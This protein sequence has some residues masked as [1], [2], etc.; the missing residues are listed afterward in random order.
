MSGNNIIQINAA[1]VAS[2]KKMNPKLNALKTDG[3]YLEYNNEKIDI[4]EI[5]MQDILSNPN[6]Y[7]SISSIE[8][9]DLFNIIKIHVEAMKIKEKELAE[10][11]R[12]ANAYE[13]SI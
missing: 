3:H 8:A 12:R 5:Y 6:L 13:Y 1:Y 4:S 7:Y 2:W 11:V 9:N 10:K